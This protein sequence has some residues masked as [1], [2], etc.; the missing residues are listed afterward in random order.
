MAL[1]GDADGER[2][3]GG[4]GRDRLISARGAVGKGIKRTENSGFSLD[5]AVRVGAHD[6]TGLERLLRYCARPPFALERLERLDAERVVYRLPKPQRNGITALTLTPLELI[7][8]LAALIPPPRR[9]R[10]RYHGVLA[11]NAPLRAAAVVL[12]RELT[13]DPSACAELAAPRR[14]PAPNARSPARYLWAM[15]LARLLLAVEKTC[16]NRGADMHI[17]AFITEAV[18]PSSRS[19]PT[20]VSHRVHP[21]SRPP[22]DRPPGT[23]HPSRCRT[24][25]SSSSPSPTSSSISASPGSRRLS[26][27]QRCSPSRL[28]VARCPA[29]ARASTPERARLHRPDVR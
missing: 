10:H 1:G 17:I 7:D 26:R 12:G 25:T 15:L 13:D 19:S 5:A 22:A 16:P 29:D 4:S 28:P 23:R 14:A 9:H 3:N 18:R 8:H 6:R 2:G 11:P 27:R 20:S 21:R 24:G